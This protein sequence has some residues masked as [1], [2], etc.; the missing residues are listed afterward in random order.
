MSGNEGEGA[1]SASTAAAATAHKIA[2]R[3]RRGNSFLNPGFG[4][5]SSTNFSS[6][7]STI[8]LGGS[9]KK[10]RRRA[11]GLRIGKELVFIDDRGDRHFAGGSAAFDSDPRVLCSRCG[12]FSVSVISG[13]RVSVKSILRI[14]LNRRID[15]EADSA[16]ADVASL[17]DVLFSLLIFAVTNAYR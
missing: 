9:G 3:S 8:S 6:V 4:W 12:W 2:R 1:P 14:G 15:I 7:I 16:S 10:A 5:K 11:Q 17:R 13:G